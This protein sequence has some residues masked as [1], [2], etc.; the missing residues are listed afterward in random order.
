MISRPGPEHYPFRRRPQLMRFLVLGGLVGLVAG[1]A[2]AVFGPD[3]PDSSL[4]QEIIL[5][6]A[7][8]LVFG[9]FFGSIVY[10]FADRQS[11][12]K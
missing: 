10:L 11:L 6:G 5:L 4:L 3:A 9:G 8:G 12:K 1:F 2:L 7:I